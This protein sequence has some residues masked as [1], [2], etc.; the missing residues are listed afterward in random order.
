MELMTLLPVSLQKGALQLDAYQ[1]LGHS[2]QTSTGFLAPTWN[3]RWLS[4]TTRLL[5]WL[6]WV[7]VCLPL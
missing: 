4:T 2:G 7:I 6:S 5:F 1:T 3:L